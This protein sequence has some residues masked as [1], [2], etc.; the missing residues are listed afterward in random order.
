VAAGVDNECQFAFG[1]MKPGLGLGPSWA[2]KQ[3]MKSWHFVI[4]LLA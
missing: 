3:R 4:A 1:Q 2:A